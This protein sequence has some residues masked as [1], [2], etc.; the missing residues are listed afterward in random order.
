MKEPQL[1]HRRT[2]NPRAKFKVPDGYPCSAR[3]RVFSFLFPVAIRNCNSRW[4]LMYSNVHRSLQH[5]SRRPLDIR[6][7]AAARSERQVCNEHSDSGK[8]IF[9]AVVGIVVHRT[10]AL[11]CLFVREGQWREIGCHERTTRLDIYSR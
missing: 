3:L 11:P 9:N 10:T 6:N 4:I 5:F 7:F 1:T 2:I 8:D